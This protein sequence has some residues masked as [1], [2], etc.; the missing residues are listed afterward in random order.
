MI[1]SL[2]FSDREVPSSDI[3]KLITELDLLPLLIKRYLERTCCSDIVPTESE[4]I[5]FQKSFL[6]REKI[7][8]HQDLYNWLSI[9]DINEPQLSR[10]MFFALQLKQFKESK[11]SHKVENFFLE[12]KNALDK[13]MYSLI[14]TRERA[15]VNELHLRI[16]E[17][18]DTFADLASEFSEGV[19][20]QVNGLIGPIELGRINP[21]I[22]ERLRISKPGQLWEPFQQ[23]D[24]WVL[25]RL[26][27]L[28]PA[29]LDESMKERIIND[30]H[31]KWMQK[32]VKTELDLVI[33]HNPDVNDILKPQPLTK[34]QANSS[35]LS[36]SMIQALDSEL[37]RQV[38]KIQENEKNDSA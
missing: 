1:N 11:F 12:S 5:A 18:E 19:E 13:A 31:N 30:M 16:S 2:K 8:N 4:Q 32:K 38:H 10:Q 20:N 36:A 17:E 24:W 33:T 3:L 35:D 15:K 9:N 34:S 29:K 14:R 28:I 25:L 23:N 21:S 27:K 6:L 37:P 22:A 7:F 26:E